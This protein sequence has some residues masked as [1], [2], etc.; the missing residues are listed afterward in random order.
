V[1][2]VSSVVLSRDWRRPDVRP[3]DQPAAAVQPVCRADPSLKGGHYETPGTLQSVIC[4]LQSEIK[5]DVPVSQ[6][7]VAAGV[8]NQS[9]LA[10]T[11]Y[12]ST[13][14]VIQGMTEGII[15]GMIDW[16]IEGMIDWIIP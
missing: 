11:T 16:M 9:C 8:T 4:T 14:W 3:A 12:P 6:L 13:P 7:S 2:S 1:F 15:Q 5:P 10:P